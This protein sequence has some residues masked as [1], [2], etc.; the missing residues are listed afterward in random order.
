MEAVRRLTTSTVLPRANLEL[1]NTKHG[2]VNVADDSSDAYE[3]NPIH[4]IPVRELFDAAMTPDTA[5]FVK[6]KQNLYVDE[7]RR[8]KHGHRCSSSSSVGK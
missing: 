3:A 5:L 7:V 8:P 6:E 2:F 4:L 1:E